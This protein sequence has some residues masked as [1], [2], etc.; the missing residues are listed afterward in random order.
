[1]P[2]PTGSLHTGLTGRA[3]QGRAKIRTASPTVS[4]QRRHRFRQPGE[5]LKRRLPAPRAPPRHAEAPTL[6]KSREHGPN[7]S[8]GRPSSCKQNAA[9]LLDRSPVKFPRCHQAKQRLQRAVTAAM[10]QRFR[11]GHSDLG[12]GVIKGVSQTSYGGTPATARHRAHCKEPPLR[13]GV[14]LQLPKMAQILFAGNHS[15]QSDAPQDRSRATGQGKKL[16]RVIRAQ[17]RSEGLGN[18]RVQRLGLVVKEGEQRQGRLSGYLPGEQDCRR[19]VFCTVAP[20]REQRGHQGGVMEIRFDLGEAA[21]C[22]WRRC[23]AGLDPLAQAA[24]H[25]HPPLSLQC[26]EMIPQGIRSERGLALCRLG[27]ED[28]EKESPKF[29]RQVGLLLAA[30]G[31]ENPHPFIL[32]QPKSGGARRLTGERRALREKGLNTGIG[33]PY[34]NFLGHIWFDRR[35]SLVQEVRDMGQICLPKLEREVF[36]HRV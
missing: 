7:I 4:Q 23:H 2:V 19:T 18:G 21:E 35:R 8:G 26:L 15:F 11:C 5:G 3:I 27:A 20:S 10:S 13:L 30:E 31:C 28:I 16:Q 36:V 32:G 14:L 1:M 25:E 34:G 29:E 6:D 24:K 12:D 22:R 17:T 33:L 9:T